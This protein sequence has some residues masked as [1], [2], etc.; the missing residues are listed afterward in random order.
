QRTKIGRDGTRDL[1]DA[2]VVHVD[3]HHDL[4][5]LEVVPDANGRGPFERGVALET[6]PAADQQTVIA[7]GFPGMAGAPSYQVT[8]GYVSNRRV[9]RHDGDLSTYVQHTA[10]TDPG[11]SGGPLLS[12]RGRL[13]GI[14]TLKIRGREG[15]AFAVPADLV[16]EALRAAE[17]RPVRAEASRGARL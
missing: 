12:E 14:N 8:R 3:P 9:R 4:A 5:V 15:V 2:E 16:V 10:P 6:T 11:S 1:L 17:S 7:A 13:I